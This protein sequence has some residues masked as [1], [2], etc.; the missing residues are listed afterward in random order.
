MPSS[1]NKKV[2]GPGITSPLDNLLSQEN[3]KVFKDWLD[4]NGEKLNLLKDQYFPQLKYP[5]NFDGNLA[6]KIKME[7]SKIHLTN[8]E[9][10]PPVT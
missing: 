1:S 6:E 3:V 2:S 4:V 8:Y 9:L 5:K 7:Y 10:I